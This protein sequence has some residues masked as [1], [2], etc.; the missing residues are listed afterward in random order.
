M[1]FWK[2][3]FAMVLSFLPGI[4]GIIVAPMET[5][6]NFWYTTLNHSLLTPPGWMFS[7][8]W[9]IL[10]FLIGLALFFVMQTDN[11]KSRYSKTKAYILF[12]INLVLNLL[13]SFVF[14]G[15]QA[16]GW[17]VLILIALIIDV[18][19]MMREFF[20]INQVS[21]WLLLPYVLWLFFALYLNAMIIYLN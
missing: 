4:L 13:W 3:V 15:A 1:N 10:Y 14:F 5:G 2:F 16:P 9:A 21:L 11:A 8:A 20:R 19:Y 18:I 6:G 17:A 7:V 12:A